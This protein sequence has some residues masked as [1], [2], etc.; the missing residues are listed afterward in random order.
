MCRNHFDQNDITG[1]REELKRNTVPLRSQV[2]SNIDSVIL[3]NS[4]ESSE[5]SENELEPVEPVNQEASFKNCCNSC[6]GYSIRI[7][8]MS[9]ENFKLLQIIEQKN[10]KIQE[11]HDKIDDLRNDKKKLLK[12]NDYLNKSK[13][14]MQNT[15]EDDLKVHEVFLFFQSTVATTTTKIRAT[16]ATA[17][18]N[19]MVCNV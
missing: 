19:K 5:I 14:K 4:N 13:K 12:K 11:L 15:T 16:V 10:D 1:K 8:E 2:T 7:D 9:N 6:S 18:T 17:Y 3:N